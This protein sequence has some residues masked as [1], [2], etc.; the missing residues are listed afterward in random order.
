MRLTDSFYKRG[1]E[2]AEGPL[3]GRS[4]TDAEI[5]AMHAAYCAGGNERQM[6]PHVVYS[7][8]T[9]PHAGCSQRMQAIDFRLE[10]HGRD[11]HDPSCAHGGT[12]QVLSV[13]VP[14]AAAGF[15]S[16]FNPRG[17]LTTRK[18]HNFRSCPTTGSRK[19]RSF[20]FRRFTP[21]AQ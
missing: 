11:V 2:M 20:D 21:T 17:T 6:A 5:R 14:H 13:A 8:E 10:S 12:T 19:P 16:R 7:E 18:R 4:P 15:I 1:D 3:L 9:C